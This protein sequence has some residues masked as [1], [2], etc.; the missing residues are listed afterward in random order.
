V[1][2]LNQGRNV[3]YFDNIFIIKKKIV[4]SSCLKTSH[5]GLSLNAREL[6]LLFCFVLLCLFVC[7][8]GYFFSMNLLFSYTFL[9]FH[10][11]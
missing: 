11:Y 6:V 9:F 7:L 10:F 2:K 5:L 8:I 4:R 3:L 1:L